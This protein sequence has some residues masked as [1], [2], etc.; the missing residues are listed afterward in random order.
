MVWTLDANGVYTGNI[1]GPGSGTSFAFE[2]LEST[3]GQD[4]NGDGVIGLNPTRTIETT[5]ATKLVEV[6]GNFIMET[7]STNV[8]VS[9]MGGLLSESQLTSNWFP[10]GAEKTAT[11]YDFAW[12]GDAGYMVWSLDANGVYTGNLVGPGAGTSYA[13]EKFESIFNQDLNGDG[14]IGLTVASGGALEITG[15]E[16]SGVSFLG[17]TGTLKLD[18]PQSF[19]GVITGFTGNGTLAGSDQI[20]LTNLAYNSLHPISRQL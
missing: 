15:A 9:F 5:G 12:K 6:G 20:D 10:I 8:A 14:H 3:F 18:A 2:S 4:L 19:T 13:F 1:Y 17:S 16:S 11:G 7:G